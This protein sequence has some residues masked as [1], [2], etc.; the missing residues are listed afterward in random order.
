MTK[1]SYHAEEERAQIVV[2][3]KNGPSQRQISK[4]LSIS[5]SSIQRA[6]AKFKTEG[7][8]GNRKKSARTT[9]SR[10]DTSHETR[11]NSVPNKLL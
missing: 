8:H 2:L 4:E 7:I 9:T 6:I 10:D 1:N 11:C 5:K 3:H